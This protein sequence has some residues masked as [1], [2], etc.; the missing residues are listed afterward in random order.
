MDLKLNIPIKNGDEIYTISKCKIQKLYV[1]KVEFN[2]LIKDPYND[3][4]NSI[5]VIAD[6][7][8][9]GVNF[10]EFK[11]RLSMCFLSK[12]DLIKQL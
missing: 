11:V 7:Y 4:S 12:E 10:C 6:S 2:E 1:T 9:D 8:N 3:V 5:N